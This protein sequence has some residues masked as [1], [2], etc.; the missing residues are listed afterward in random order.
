MDHN[1]SSLRLGAAAILCAVA[2]RLGAGPV[3][4]GIRRLFQS[5]K[6]LSFLVYTETGRH[7][8]FSTSTE[9]VPSN[10]GESPAPVIL[11]KA[12]DITSFSPED[13]TLLDVQGSASTQPDVAA[14]LTKPLT[15]N[16]VSDVPTVLILHT[17][18]TESYTKGTAQYRE[19]AAFRT[20]DEGYN[21]ISIGAHLAK[22]LE[23]SGIRV[24]HD[25]TLHDY[26]SYNGSYNLARETI[27]EYLQQYPSIS[28]VLDLHRDASGDI[29]NQICPVANVG[30]E[31]AAQ[32]MLVM[33]MRHEKSEENL[34]LGLKLHAQLERIAPGIMRPISL[35]QSRY[36][37]DLSPGALL[38]E[39]GAAGNTQPQALRA[40]EV[41]A[42]GI[43]ALANGT[44]ES[45]T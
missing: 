20:L 27:T 29:S 6:F 17:H 43:I 24:I 13:T 36:N 21:M 10:A 9:P 37:Q 28:L 35:R 45:G 11:P 40:A 14:L 16:L 15:W 5:E 25:Q 18:A 34:A 38:I 22:L 30:G 44:K 3:Y 23:A 2:L 19:T 31:T 12:I 26:P 39:V 42:Q 41:L 1:R 8:R 32:L 33:G 4:T 7:V